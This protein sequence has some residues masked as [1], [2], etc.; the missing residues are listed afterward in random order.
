[1]SSNVLT[2]NGTAPSVNGY[3]LK[4]ESNNPLD[5]PSFTMRF[6]FSN[7][8]YVPTNETWYGEGTKTWT[9]VSSNPNVWDYTT[10]NR[11]W[12]VRFN[13]KFNDPDNIVTV[14]G[15]NTTRV[16][17]FSSCFSNNSSLE[18]LPQF[19]TSSV[20]NMSNMF[21]GASRITTIPLFDTSSVT[22]MMNMFINATSLVTIPLIDCSSVRNVQNMFS[23]CSALTE[24]PLLDFS[25][26]TYAYG[27]CNNCRALRHIP[28]FNTATW[29][30]VQYA[31]HQCYN[32]E[33][34]ALALYNRMSSQAVPPTN[35]IATFYMTGIDTDTGRAELE[36]IPSDWK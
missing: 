11:N 17:S 13:N 3:W 12:Q 34:G 25:S 26:V 32:V 33:S 36:Q 4:Y 18:N 23:G 15:A 22:N 28:L 10:N 9:R 35:H 30:N 5:L 29:V 21:N 8:S 1:M 31:F 7:L 14:L 20:T 2:Y 6:Q 16:E 24:L 27:M 19:D